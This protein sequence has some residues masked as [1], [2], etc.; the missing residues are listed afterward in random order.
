MSYSLWLIPHEQN[1]KKYLFK[2][3]SQLAKRHNGPVF[4]PHL[5]ILGDVDLSLETL[6][7]KINKVVQK[8]RVLI[9]ETSTVEYSSTYFQCVFVRVKP[10]PDLMQLY[11]NLKQNLGLTKSSVFM[12]HISLLYGD[13]PY[14]ERHK[15]ANSLRLETQVFSS[16][17][18]VITP[19]GAD[20]TP[21]KWDHLK[22]ISFRGHTI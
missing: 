17:S 16:E 7:D 6:S 14:Q 21:D 5:T 1:P 13:F 22:E 3:T 15:I 12:P 20:V 2:V 4:E 19:S 18:I 10:T 8:T 9:L 11:D